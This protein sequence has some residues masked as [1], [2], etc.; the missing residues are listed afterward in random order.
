ME[1]FITTIPT[2]LLLTLVMLLSLCWGSFLACISFRIAFDRPLFTARSHCPS[3]TNM[4][5]WYNN[6]P[7]FSWFILRGKCRQCAATISVI[8]AFIEGITAI[9]MTTLF[10]KTFLLSLIT[11]SSIATFCLNVILF[12][13]LIGSTATDLFAMVIPQLFSIWLVPLGVLGAHCSLL[14]IDPVSS[15]L[16]AMFGYGFLKLVAYV[17]K[18]YTDHEGM[19]IGDMELLCLIGSFTGLEGCWI[20]LLLASVSGLIIGGAFLH[21]TS[22]SKRAHIPFGP[23]LAMGAIIYVLFTKQLV[24][25]FLF[26]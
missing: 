5:A 8:Y 23:F 7:L 3:C 15:M 9:C 12:S 14:G 18:K 10:Y 17:F 21:L 25:L 16:G 2:P 20:T 19:G 6:I 24:Q 22:Q 4:I 11:P 13:A 26:R 1:T